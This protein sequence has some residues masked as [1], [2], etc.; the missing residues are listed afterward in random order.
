MTI[1]FVK[2]VNG[3]VV[4][5]AGSDK[6]SI[7]PTAT[8][9][10]AD[11]GS[12]T[13]EWNGKELNVKASDV[14]LPVVANVDALFTELSTNY[15]DGSSINTDYGTRIDSIEADDVIIK[16]RVTDLEE[17]DQVIETRLTALE[18][19]DILVK[20]YET[21]A[22][23]TS[24][25]VTT[26]AHSTIVL[27]KFGGGVDAVTYE[28]DGS[29]VPTAVTAKKAG[30]DPVVTTLNVAKAW[31]FDEAPAAYP[32][33]IEFYIRIKAAYLSELNAT[34]ILESIQI[35]DASDV[36][37][38]A[39]T[40]ADALG[41][42]ETD[43][44]TH[45]NKTVLDAIEQSLTSVLKTAYD[46]AVSASHA[47]TNKAILDAIEQ[48]LTSALKTAYDG[49][50]SDSHTHANKATLDAI[51]QAFTTALKSSY[52]G[53]VSA[54][55]AHTN[56]AN[57][58]E[59]DQDLAKADVP[60]FAGVKIGDVAGGNYLEIEADG[61]IIL[62]GNATVFNDL[63]FDLIPKTSGGGNPTLATFIGA[64]KKYT[65]AVNDEVA[66]AKGRELPHGWKEGSIAEIHIHLCT[67]GTYVNNR[68]V[69]FEVGYTLADMGGT[70]LGEQVITK[71]VTIP[72]NTPDRHHLYFSIADIDLTGFHFGAQFEVRLKR[73]TSTG[74]APSSDPFIFGLALHLEYN[75]LGSREEASN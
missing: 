7:P 63:E 34:K 74:L 53:A 71:E 16:G 13:I 69:K 54:S 19:Q 56:K 40:V 66:N 33:C 10:K 27:D 39:E 8:I 20:Y 22:E 26:S 37:Y 6:I 73:I 2:L 1:S 24:G 75:K 46:G 51:Q 70:Y 35:T 25:S 47:H 68:Y 61:T 55:H 17:A 58:D 52:D 41:S 11:G 4:Y 48:S 36:Q 15:F 21:I 57:L 43:S 60:E 64:I 50:V 38:G 30:G 31:T 23:G 65:W 3:N 49:A 32:V 14:V 67:N 9:T 5:T 62:H 12:V 28:A 44:H 45:S 18:N 59:I 42:L 29:G 72:A